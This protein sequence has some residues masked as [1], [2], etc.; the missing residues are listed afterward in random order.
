MMSAGTYYIGDLCYVIKEWDEVCKL[1]IKGDNCIDGEFVL[2]DGRRFANY[3]TEYG[4]GIYGSN[5]GTMH[6][7]DSGRIGCIK[8]EDI[9][10]VGASP[11]KLGAIVTFDNDFETDSD[12]GVIS[13]GHV[14]V[15]TDPDD[16]EDDD[17]HDDEDE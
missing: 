15:D 16:D 4:D 8:V 2:P 17:Y 11:S 6:P 5:I 12:E 14:E 1:I 9:T 7:V 13:F 3:G 10:I